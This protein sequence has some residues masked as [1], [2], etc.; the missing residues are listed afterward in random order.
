M[1]KFS[2]MKQLYLSILTSLILFSCSDK[3]LSKNDILGKYGE[4]G[5]W[6]FEFKSNLDLKSYLKDTA[7]I[8]EWMLELENMKHDY[9]GIV[10]ME[11][12]TGEAGLG[13]WKYKGISD[14]GGTM[15][16]ITWQ[17]YGYLNLS[18]YRNGSW[19]FKK[20]GSDIYFTASKLDY[21]SKITTWEKQ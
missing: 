13:L 17:K 12:N 16:Y 6:Y 4:N 8:P 20:S 9:D 5:D 18:L 7:N 1:L 15:V 19:Y 2:N 11:K 21:N 3:E 10:Y 14:W